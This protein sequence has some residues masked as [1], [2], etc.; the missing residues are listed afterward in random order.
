ME[1]IASL[2]LEEGVNISVSGAEK[3]DKKYQH[4]G[5]N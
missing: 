1:L 4:S 3:H 2:K 5:K